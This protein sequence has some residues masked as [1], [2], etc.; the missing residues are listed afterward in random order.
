[1]R[2]FIG[3]RREDADKKGE[4]RVA[5]VPEL[6]EEMAEKG[7]QFWVQPAKHPKNGE[8]KRAFLD[9]EYAYAGA[10]IDEDLQDCRVI[11]G[12][13]EIGIDHILSQK[14][15]LFF[16]HTH[17]GQIKNRPMLKKLVQQKASLI[18]YELIQHKEGGRILTSFTYFAG[19]AGMIDSLWTLGKRL[20]GEG[21]NTVFS[22]IPQAVEKGDLQ[23]IRNLFH[24][25]GMKIRE[26][27]TPTE[28]PPVIT[29][30]LGNGKTSS[31]AQEIYDIL[32]VREIKLH[33]LQ[34]TYEEGDRKYIY[35][36]VLDIP[37]MYRFKMDSPYHEK[38]MVRT[39]L[40]NLYLKEPY[41]FESNLD[42]VFP[43]SMMMM[44]CIIWAP[45][46][47]RLL[48]REDTA[49]WHKEH[50]TLR[51]IGDITCD[52]EGA[53]QFSKETWIDRP[54]FIYDPQTRNEKFGFEGEGIAVMA[55]TN[56]PCEFPADAS[57]RFSKELSPYLPA[58]LLA[59][60]DSNSPEEAG[61]PSEIVGATILWK[62]KFT[63]TYKYMSLFITD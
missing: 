46:F 61:L 16:S 3:I 36:L 49:R 29:C 35:K 14:T 54:V 6:V 47:P 5:I 42:Q 59:D 33:E 58:I 52:P 51:V 39:D 26:N 18:D 15:Y 53:I 25:I 32:P 41:H 50:K 10:S 1:M 20:E 40:I 9:T 55:V 31:G 24:E 57:S 62:G 21:H 48:S 23:E 2:N 30:F 19:Y 27:G 60:Y 37:E 56:L 38:K 44:N 45:E 17:K 12:L 28:L 8:T 7:F 63:P 4:K 34:E 13:K 22:N 43:Y 11:F